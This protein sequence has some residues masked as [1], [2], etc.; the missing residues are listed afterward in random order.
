[1]AYDFSLQD[2]M[3]NFIGGAPGP[4]EPDMA[5]TATTGAVVTPQITE[6]KPGFINPKLALKNESV[7]PVADQGNTYNRILQAESNNQDYD[8]QGRPITSPKGAMFAGQV[9]PSTAANP[10]FG[11]KP[12]ASQ[13]PEEYNRVSSEYYQAMLK[14]YG[15]DEQKAV[16]AY[17]AGPGTVDRNLAANKGQLNV[18]QLPKETQTYLGKVRPQQS[19]TIPTTQTLSP[20]EQIVNQPAAPGEY[21]G[22]GIG[23]GA[24]QPYTGGG[25]K[26]PGG[27]TQFQLEQEQGY[28]SVLNS[29][30]QE[31]IGK[32]AFDMNTP[33]DIQRAA[34]DKLYQ[35]N[36]VQTKVDEVTKKIE[37]MK[38]APGGINPRDI[39]KAMNDRDT[40]NIFK[41]IFYGLMGAKKK[42]E[43]EWDKI[44]P[45]VT[46]KGVTME[47]GTRVLAKI[48]ANTGETLGAWK[49]GNP[50]TDAKTL[51]DIATR[52]TTGKWQTTAEFFQ[53]KKGNVFQAQHNDQGDT[54]IVDTKTNAP[55]TGK[56]PLE[57]LRDTSKLTQMET[58]QGY[59]REN[60]LTR[61]AN[62]IATLDYKA[63][64]D[65]VSKYRQSQLDD[66]KPDLN[67]A[68]LS[69]LGI[70]RPSFNQYISTGKVGE[71]A[72]KV[73]APTAVPPQGGTQVTKVVPNSAAATGEVPPAPVVSQPPAAPV[74]GGRITPNQAEE[75]KAQDK[76]QRDI[77]TAQIKE[78]DQANQKYSTQL[79]E[80]YRNAP[81]QLATINRVQKSIDKNPEFFGIVSNSPGMQAFINAQSDEKKYEALTKLYTELNIQPT[82]RAEFDAVVNDYRSLAVSTITNSGLTASQT[83]TERESQRVIGIVG[84]MNDKPAAAKA[85]L[86]Y[87]KAKVEYQAAKARAWATERKTNKGIDQLD[88]EVNFN[89]TQ[90]EKIF[91][92]ANK[93]MEKIIGG[94]AGKTLSADDTKAVEWANAHPNDPRAKRIKESLGQ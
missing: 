81:A 60:D 91:A 16:A 47:D 15:G 50:I 68:E 11:I 28:H 13:T 37:A 61:F 43:E 85:A 38:A 71:P 41:A 87:A 1:M 21:T 65:A 88:F 23:E 35:T 77:D 66:G 20:G 5:T 25:L 33:K 56:E 29:N 2:V 42:E 52:S 78:R 44:D 73:T 36:S 58:A 10:G 69:T 4:A 39:N 94:T 19:Q 83:N 86:E 9:M 46:Y 6:T 7:A 40:G 59:R 3:G 8:A 80:S 72:K 24:Y 75:K 48:A 79:A 54:R 27:Q 32:M 45:K 63:K 51:N 18:A 22:P 82:K 14:K 26:T 89:A 74:L 55:Y 49:D 84:S 31:Q 70:T 62:S 57:R 64:L 76:A 67:D 12:A 92:D 30:S 53:D 34:L 90:G 93:R 17:N